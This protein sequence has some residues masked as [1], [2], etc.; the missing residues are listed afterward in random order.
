[1][2]VVGVV[3]EADECVG[4]G[5]CA[6][7]VEVVLEVEVEVEV[8]CVL[9]VTVAAGVVALT[10]GHDCETLVIALFGGSGSELGGVPGAMFWKTRVSGGPTGRA[11][12]T[13]TVQPLA[14]AFGNAA[15]PSTVTIDPTVAAAI[16]S[17]RLLNTVA[18]SSRG[19][20]REN[21]SQFR[22]QVGLQGR[23]WLPVSFAI[24]N[25]RCGACLFG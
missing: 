17:F 24:G 3:D 21:S 2:V 8:G 10:G 16:V 12:V 23:Y 13:V 9:V 20:P 14:N 5:L 4:F 7:V 6:G 25:R 1:V 19:M 15:N 22:T 18:Y 11:T